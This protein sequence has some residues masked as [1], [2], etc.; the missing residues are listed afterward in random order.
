[1]LHLHGKPRL[2][3]IKEFR[4]CTPPSI[5][6][7][8]WSDLIGGTYTSASCT[9]ATRGSQA[10]PVQ[11][12]SITST[13]N[14]IGCIGMHFLCWWAFCHNCLIFRY[15]DF[16]FGAILASFRGPRAARHICSRDILLLTGGG[17]RLRADSGSVVLENAGACLTSC[18]LARLS[19]PLMSRLRGIHPNLGTRG[20]AGRKHRKFGFIQMR[21]PL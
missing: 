12:K 4:K 15:Q 8:D 9:E 1:M 7:E 21:S 16:L 6:S 10:R 5:Y 18:H 17:R 2:G 14:H 13:L 20:G 3:A 19:P 11:K